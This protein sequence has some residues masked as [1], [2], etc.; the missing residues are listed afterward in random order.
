MPLLPNGCP[1]LQ[2]GDITQVENVDYENG[3]PK[4][5]YGMRLHARVEAIHANGDVDFKLIS[6]KSER[7]TPRQQ[8]GMPCAFAEKKYVAGQDV[9][10]LSVSQ[11]YKY[12]EACIDVA[13]ADG[14]IQLVYSTGESKMLSWEQQNSMVQV[15][16]QEYP[17][18]EM[19]GLT[20]TWSYM[21]APMAI[22]SASLGVRSWDM[23]L[24]EFC[25]LYKNTNH[26]GE[27]HG[28]KIKPHFR[29]NQTGSMIE[30]YIPMS[31]EEEAYSLGQDYPVSTMGDKTLREL[32]FSSDFENPGLPNSEL[33]NSTF[34][35]GW[36]WVFAHSGQ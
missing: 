6:G 15:P 22:R 30:K 8:A 21:A 19:T 10:V 31:P 14:R 36:E 33:P 23:P 3:N 17:L 5:K 16:G 7:L 4:R 2:L 11:G 24:S 29:C 25:A 27:V 1:Q 28:I 13:H 26:D 9:L 32:G 35:F 20:V 12:V 18:I 34:S